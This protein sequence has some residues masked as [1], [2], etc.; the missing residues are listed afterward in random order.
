[1]TIHYY[2]TTIRFISSYHIHHISMV[3]LVTCDLWRLWLRTA[4]AK[5]LTAPWIRFQWVLQ[6]IFRMSTGRLPNIFPDHRDMSVIFIDF[7]KGKFSDGF[8]WLVATCG[9]RFSW[10][11]L[12]PRWSKAFHRAAG[13]VPAREPIPRKISNASPGVWRFSIDDIGWYIRYI[14]GKLHMIMQQNAI[15]INNHKI[16][17]L[18]VV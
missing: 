3:C 18:K 4:M 1:M 11:L 5:L 9:N 15:A 7:Q 17:E 6:V 14:I 13:G 16:T 12:D 2:V 8:F 10:A